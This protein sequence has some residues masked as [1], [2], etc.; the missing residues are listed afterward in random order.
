MKKAL[1]SLMLMVTTIILSAQT[2]QEYETPNGKIHFIMDKNGRCIS[3]QQIIGE[4]QN[5]FSKIKFSKPILEKEDPDKL[6]RPFIENKET[7][8]LTLSFDEP[9]GSNTELIIT[10]NVDSYGKY[11]L[12]WSDDKLTGEIDLPENTYQIFAE[13]NYWQTT[14]NI[15]F[16]FIHDLNV[17]MDKDTIISYSSMA[18]HEIDSKCFDENG[19]LLDPSDTT[20][21]RQQ[22]IINIEFPTTCLFESCTVISNIKPSGKIRFSDVNNDYKIII[23]NFYVRFNK[24]YITDIG[25][26]NGLTKDTVIQNIPLE[27]KKMDAVIHSSPSSLSTNYLTFEY[28][29]ISRYGTTYMLYLFGSTNDDH[30]FANLDTLHVFMKNKEMPENRSLVA[31]VSGINFW[32]SFPSE[33]EFPAPKIISDPFHINVS[34]SIVFTKWNVSA[35]SPQYPDNSVVDLGNTAPFNTATFQNNMMGENTIYG[36]SISYGQTNEERQMDNRF[37]IYEIK[38]GDEILA[39]DTISN[40]IDPFTV[41]GQGV[42]TFNITNNNYVVNDQSGQ[43][44]FEASFDIGNADANPPVISSFKLLNSENFITNSFKNNE[45][46]TILLSSFDY[47]YSTYK[48]NEPSS[49]LVFYKKF[50][51]NDWSVLNMIENPTLFDSVNYGS[52]YTCDFSPALT[53]FTTSGY[54]DL[55]IVSADNAGNTATQILHPAAYVENNVGIPQIIN[56][57]KGALQIYPNPVADNSVISFNLTQ[58]SNV[59]LSVY[60]I[61]GQ[62][63]EALLDKTMKKGNHQISWNTTNY[64][65]EKLTSGIYLLKLETGNTVKIS[66]VIVK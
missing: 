4:N 55:K 51:S 22:K 43:G 33:E 24:L 3:M 29:G 56:N 25:Q 12:T 36:Y 6:I 60:N 45:F 65:G 21:L 48:L 59:K 52:F 30:P 61:N 34:D 42:Y 1:L 26:L 2:H 5:T 11:D 66:K 44:I 54:L 20:L 53:Q 39:S 41:T 32:E 28:G 14:G 47:N 7:H 57:E 46:A 40:F 23:N 15:A 58:N 31:F 18:N 9:M 8:H 49:V 16:V 37:S 17:N 62:L 64:S 13:C 63:M 50:D 27:Y 38:K 10:S 19:I 35:A